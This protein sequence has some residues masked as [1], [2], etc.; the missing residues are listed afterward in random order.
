MFSNKRTPAEV[1]AATTG[2]VDIALAGFM[3]TVHKLDAHAAVLL[4][5]AQ[6]SDRT[7]THHQELSAQAR[8]AASNTMKKAARIAELIS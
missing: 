8:V 1:L 6:E 4:D 3:D 2:A 7:A 5:L